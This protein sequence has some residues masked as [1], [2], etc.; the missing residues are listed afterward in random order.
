MNHQDSSN[1]DI[2][3]KRKLSDVY[4]KLK[5]KKNVVVGIDIDLEKFWSL[6]FEAWKECDRVSVLNK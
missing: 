4:D 5:Q 1:K 6:V 3:I 2:N